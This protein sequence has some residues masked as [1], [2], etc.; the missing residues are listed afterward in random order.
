[1][2]QAKNTKQKVIDGYIDHV[3]MHGQRPVSVYAFCKSIG[4]KEKDFYEYF[5]NLEGIDKSIWEKFFDDTHNKL[6]AEKVYEEYSVRE[7]LLAFYYTL[8]EVLKEY[9]SYVMF[10]VERHKKYG[11]LATYLKGFRGKFEEY[12]KNL[13]KAGVESEEIEDR[14]LLTDKYYR[15]FW[16]QL[17]F[18]MDFWCRDSSAKFEKTDAAI[19]K[20]VNLSFELLGKNPIDSI[21]DFGKFIFQNR[22]SV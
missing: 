13:V 19:E 20:A 14:K 17:L 7:K 11:P 21:F 15:G 5:G 10:T 1:M 12:V 3:L 6:L 2:A 18:V 8:F 16:I 9:R 22:A 4:I